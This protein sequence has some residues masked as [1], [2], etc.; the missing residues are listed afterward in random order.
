MKEAAIDGL[1]KAVGGGPGLSIAATVLIAVGSALWHA[2]N[3]ITSQGDD[4][5]QLNHTVTEIKTKSDA[6]DLQLE[7]IAIG[8]AQLQGQV[9]TV[10]QKID[11]Q[12]KIERFR[13]Q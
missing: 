6:R 1:M 13:H 5:Q 9:A 4:I 2:S 3:Q 12:A 10:N 11:D 8:V 7:G